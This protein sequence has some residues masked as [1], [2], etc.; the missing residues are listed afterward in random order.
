ALLQPRVEG[1]HVGE[2]RVAVVDR[3]DGLRPLVEVGGDDEAREMLP[4]LV[5]RDEAGVDVVGRVVG[6]GDL[7]RVAA[8]EEEASLG[9]SGG[10]AKGGEGAGAA[11]VGVPAADT[12][13]AT[14]G[15]NEAPLGEQTNGERRDEGV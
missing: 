4:V 8:L 5:A 12:G 7:D 1:Q 15:G 10:V 9:M 2:A 3:A 6:A 11:D 13:P 14:K